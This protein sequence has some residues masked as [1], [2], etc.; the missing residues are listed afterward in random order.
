MFVGYNACDDVVEHKIRSLARKT[1]LVR[2]MFSTAFHQ[3]REPGIIEAKFLA[4][5]KTN[6]ENLFQFKN[7][8]LKD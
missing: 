6:Q 3:Y 8:V 4:K 1:P 5:G 2:M 7:G